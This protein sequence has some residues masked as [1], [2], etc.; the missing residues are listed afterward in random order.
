MSSLFLAAYLAYPNEN[1]DK[2]QLFAM[3]QP[4]TSFLFFNY[5]F[6]Y[7]ITLRNDL[8]KNKGIFYFM[9]HSAEDFIQSCII[10]CAQIQFNYYLE[11]CGFISILTVLSYNL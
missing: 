6:P 10:G 3:V 11:D 2:L 4:G 9:T 5:L 8:K 1:E 7:I